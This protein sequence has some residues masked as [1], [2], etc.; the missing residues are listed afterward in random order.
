[1]KQLHASLEASGLPVTDAP[2]SEF[3]RGRVSA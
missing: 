3:L 2:D 1:M